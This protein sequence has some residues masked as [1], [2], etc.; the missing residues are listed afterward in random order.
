MMQ[1][2]RYINIK[3]IMLIKEGKYQ[4]LHAVWLHSREI[5][6]SGTSTELGSH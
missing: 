6:K 1:C 2:I 5:I 3:N 4:R